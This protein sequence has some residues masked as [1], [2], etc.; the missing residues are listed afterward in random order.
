MTRLRKKLSRSV[1]LLSKVKY[2]I[3]KYFSR[4]IYHW[5]FNF[6]LI[7]ECEIWWENHKNCYF[8]KLL[9]LQERKKSITINFK[10]QTS[11]S[12]CVFKE[13]KVLRI[14]DF[15]NYKYALFVRNSLRKENAVTFNEMFT[16]P[17]LNHNHIT[18]AAINHL[19][20]IPQK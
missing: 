8:K 10:L 16:P 5:I 11:S 9:R 19:L 6:H 3:P 13:N 12:D 14:S 18:R 2:Y 15:I 1:G 7:Y 20:D 17:N 4:T